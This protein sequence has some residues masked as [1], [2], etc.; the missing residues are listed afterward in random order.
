MAHVAT[1]V[2]R[3]IDRLL[4]DLFVAWQGLSQAAMDIDQWDLIEQIDYVE[5]WAP[6]ESQAIH[7]RRLMESP[8]ATREQHQRYEQLKRLLRTNRPILEQLRA[9]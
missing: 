6:K 9:S 4:D 7:L 2:Q 1:E 5:E 3:E 8:E